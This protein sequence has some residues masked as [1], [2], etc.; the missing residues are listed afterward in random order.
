MEDTKWAVGQKNGDC[1]ERETLMGPCD[2]AMQFVGGAVVCD[3]C[4]AIANKK[5]TA[6][7]PQ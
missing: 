2:G 6:D 1:C 7:V 5:E 3:S 4:G